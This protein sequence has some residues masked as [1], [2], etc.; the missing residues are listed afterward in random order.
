ML[1][2]L[3]FPDQTLSA[4]SAFFWPRLISAT[5]NEKLKILVAPHPF[6][7]II[8]LVFAAV[9]FALELPLNFI[10]GASIHRSIPARL[11]IY[12]LSALATGL[13]YQGI[14]ACLYTCIGMGFFIWALAEGEVM[15]LDFSRI[16]YTENLT[17]HLSRALD[18]SRCKHKERSG[19]RSYHVTKS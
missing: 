18:I 16:F 1:N 8:I 12:S 13:L 15:F 7:Q 9:L 10:S 6:L 2:T 4:I 14:N 11:V 5:L 17:D 19:E 3:T